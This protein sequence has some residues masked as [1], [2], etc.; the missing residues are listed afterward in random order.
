LIDYQGTFKSLQHFYQNDLLIAN[1][2]Y[3]SIEDCDKEIFYVKKDFLFKGGEWRGV[4]QTALSKRISQSRKPI[5]VSGHSDISAN[6]SRLVLLKAMGVHRFFGTN[7]L[8]KSS[9]TKALPTGLCDQTDATKAHLILGDNSHLVSAHENSS[10]PSIFSP[11]IELNFTV[12][13]SPRRVKLLKELKWGNNIEIKSDAPKF[14]EKTRIEYLRSCREKCFVICPPGNGKDTHRL[15]ETL[16]MG[17]IPIIKQDKYLAPLVS[18]LPV[19]VVKSWSEV[20]NEHF[21]ERSW[22]EINSRRYN[23]EKLSIQYWLH[24][25]F[26]E[27][28]VN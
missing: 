7:T 20:L 2:K 25:I 11:K 8:E 26:K 18:E 10:F 19:L 16:Y 17:G 24:L 9:F 22:F 23:F 27:V 5:V 1:D 28:R 4:E 15:W 3:H 14:S 21:L 6:F 13:N 12:A